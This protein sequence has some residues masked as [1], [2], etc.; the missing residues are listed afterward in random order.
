[1]IAGSNVTAEQ[2]AV[3]TTFP[4]ATPGTSAEAGAEGET[5]SVVFSRQETTL[6]VSPLGCLRSVTR[7]LQQRQ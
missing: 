3:V 6:L 1:M 5:E 4:S 7:N 2:S